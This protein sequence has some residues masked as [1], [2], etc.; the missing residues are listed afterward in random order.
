MNVIYVQMP[1][2]TGEGVRSLGAVVI[3][4]CELPIMLGTKYG[5]SRGTANA[6]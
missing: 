2:E 5:S 3:D 1:L 6:L 4:G